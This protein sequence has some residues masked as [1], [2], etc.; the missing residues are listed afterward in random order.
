MR[1]ISPWNLFCNQYYFQSLFILIWRSNSLSLIAFLDVNLLYM[2]CTYSHVAVVRSPSVLIS[3]TQWTAARQT[4]S[5]IFQ[6]LL[7]LM[8]TELVMPSNQLLLPQS[9]PASGSF[10][11]S[12]LSS[13]GGQSTGASASAWVLPM[14]T[15][16]WSPLGWT[17]W[18]SLQSKGL[19]RVSPTQQFQNINSSALSII[20][21]SEYSEL[22]SFR[23][24]WLDLLA[25]QGT[26]KRLLQHLA[27]QRF[28]G[29]QPSLCSNS[30]VHIWL[31]ENQSFDY[32]DLCQQGD[33]LAFLYAV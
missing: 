31:L 16:D 4:S 13:S 27:K 10:P 1:E 23:M 24:D 33:I 5:T 17:G 7:T 22:I 8:S 18:I 32:M 19:S 6:S 26:L 3:E 12:Q 28:L 11:M 25:V 2:L 29:A 15:Q 21:S 14:N 20:P 9:F 30:H